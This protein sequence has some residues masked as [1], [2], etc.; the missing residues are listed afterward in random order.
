MKANKMTCVTL[1]V[2]LVLLAVPGQLAAQ[3][4]QDQDR[5]HHHYK[6]VVIGTFG[7]PTGNYWDAL[8]N[9]SVLNRRGSTVGGADTLT[10][11]PYS[12][13]YWWSNGLISHAFLRR[14]G[15]LTDLGSLPGTNNSM[16]IWISPNGLATGFSE[17]GQIDPVV[18]DLPE[19]HAVLWGNGNMTDLGTLPQGGY[20]SEANSV[21]SRGQ[22]VGA[23]TNLVPDADSMVQA[24]F[25][26][27]NLA[28]PYQ[29][30][31]FVWDQKNGMRDLGTL[32]S[33][34]DAEATLINERG[35][36]VGH[37]YTSS[38][39]G[40]CGNGYILATGSFIWDEKHGMKDIGSFGGTCTY[41]QYLN[42][43]GQIVGEAAVSGDQGSHAF[44]WD[45]AHGLTNLGNLSGSY[46]GA[47]AIN[48]K[49]AVAGWGG[50]MGD[51]TVHAALWRH[52]GQV[53][54]LGTVDNDP[55]SIATGL[56]DETQVVGWSAPTDC[57]NFDNA[58]PFL[59]EHGSLVDLNDL[60]PPNSPLQLVYAYEINQRGE[61]AGNGWDTHGNE[62]AFLLLPCDD[63][64]PGV[65]GCDYGLVDADAATRENPASVVQRPT[66]TAPAPIV[67]ARRMLRPFGRRGMSFNPGRIGP[68][69]G[70]STIEDN[71][72]GWQAN[73]RPPLG[74]CDASNGSL[75]GY[76]TK[77]GSNP[78]HD[79]CHVTYSPTYCHPGQRAKKPEWTHCN[80]YGTPFE[81]DLLTTCQ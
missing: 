20:E 75:T 71:V 60:I 28:Y 55:C 14:D 77:P 16:S 57:V 5:K 38:A 68:Q 30:R 40:A 21:N 4:K 74:R 3:D 51:T 43:Q 17:N 54:D 44:L 18:A 22:V 29:S 15:S 42:N 27:W 62:H 49:G 58:R 31:A 39:P 66:T 33:G 59:W 63:G 36:V 53:T 72:G 41:A 13:N 35:Q 78:H 1:V 10:A 69:D 48:D 52:A 67:P 73:R 70:S 50:L 23:A 56:N 45:R 80:D 25:V 46:A 2:L 81:E 26:L 79:A 24:N 65:E 61:I 19:I 12:P 32:G 76:C 37:S 8:S 7:G 6:L 34:T 47:S 9:I 11:D 64:H